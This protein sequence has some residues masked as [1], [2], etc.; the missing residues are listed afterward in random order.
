M[1]GVDKVRADHLAAKAAT[2]RVLRHESARSLSDPAVVRHHHAVRI[3]T[4]YQPDHRVP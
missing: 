2:I 1:A 3:L 4:V